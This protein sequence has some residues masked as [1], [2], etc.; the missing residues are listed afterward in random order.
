MSTLEAMAASVPARP[1][2]IDRLARRV[3]AGRLAGI[4][5]GEIR[6]EDATGTERLGTP[7][8][9]QVSVRVHRARFF[10][11]AVLGGTMSV[12]ESYLRGDWDCDDLTAFFRIF[13]RNLETSDRLDD[14]LS[15]LAGV[16]RRIVHWCRA[17][18]RAGSRRNIQAHYDLG[19]EFYRLWLD[20]SLAYSSGIFCEPGATLR[21]ASLEKF[22]RVCRKLELCDDDHVLEIG[23]GWGGFALHAARQ[24]GCR[25]TTTTISNEQ[26]R[27]AQDRIREARMTDRVTLLQQDYRDL[28]GRF[29]KLVSI[30]MIE[31]VGERYFDGYFRKCSELLRPDGSLVL[32][33]I[34][35]PE[36]RYAQ[37]LRSVDFIQH[38]VFPGGCLPSVAAMLESAGRTTDLRF[39]HAEDFAPHYAET[40]RHWR[41]SFRA[42]LDA[43]RDLGYPERF[44]RLWNYYLCY[45]EALFEERYVGVVQIQFDKPLCRRDPIRLSAR[46]A[47]LNWCSTGTASDVGEQPEVSVCA[48]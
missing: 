48:G 24:Y 38:Y 29:D 5:R 25:V 43:V 34:V 47:G 42:R 27:L 33:A 39:V 30:E 2:L 7:S 15:R 40:L 45:C 22:D 8:D 36:R 19:N 14:G 17:N 26:F 35:M 10:R 16:C 21:D 13:V 23:T 1:G 37:Y 12:A 44:I 46:A 28:T 6:L 18:T 31:A 32:Q 3:L 20:E 9:L 4:R 11:E 41:H